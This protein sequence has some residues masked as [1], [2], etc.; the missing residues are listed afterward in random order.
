MRFLTICII[1]TI[2]TCGLLIN[3]PIARAASSN[4]DFLPTPETTLPTPD[5][6]PLIQLAANSSHQKIRSNNTT[7]HKPKYDS[8][9]RMD[10][11]Q[12][13]GDG[14]LQ[15]VEDEPKKSRDIEL[16]SV[17]NFDFV[18]TDRDINFEDPGHTKLLIGLAQLAA[19]MKFADW[20]NAR[21]SVIHTEDVNEPVIYYRPV[22]D[23][24]FAAVGDFHKFP[25]YVAFG[26]YYLPFGIYKHHALTGTFTKDLSEIRRSAATLGFEDDHFYG[27][28]FTFTRDGYVNHQPL[29]QYPVVSNYGVEGGY[30]RGED[31]YGYN[32][33][34]GFLSDL[35]D[36]DSISRV[37][38]IDIART[39][40]LAFHT[41]MY[42]NR[43]G[44]I[45]DYTSA[46]RH[47]NS[48]GITF[49]NRGAQPAALS[50]QIFMHFYT[51]S[52]A[53]TLSF[54]YQKS[55]EALGIFLPDHRYVVN[56][57]V[58][59]TRM[60]ELIFQYTYTKDYPTNRTGGFTVSDG[61]ERI[62]GTNNNIQAIAVRFSFIF[63][64]PMPELANS[65]AQK[66]PT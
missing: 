63:G 28:Y 20:L 43:Y 9:D 64:R 12:A 49:D 34:L 52:K 5:K 17:L 40:A 1:W 39:P 7:Q 30:A 6:T 32:F 31:T 54:G 59:V 38:P 14:P 58:Q 65:P 56:Y 18:S 27:S 47:Y 53:S 29:T 2:I 33:Y 61:V 24:A 21:V 10:I 37:E 26:K 62:E 4:S 51:A 44:F 42:Y 55:T 60:L 41:E 13:S 48:T 8:P 35:T 46:I 50:T 15:V 19:T 16:G 57:E 36:V 11:S 22:I 66:F 23:E 3:Q 25:L 45:I